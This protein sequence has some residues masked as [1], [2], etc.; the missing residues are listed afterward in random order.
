MDC[1]KPID[2]ETLLNQDIKSRILDLMNESSECDLH[3]Y[4]EADMHVMAEEAKKSYANPTS[5]E[6]VLDYIVRVST[7]DMYAAFIDDVPVGIFCMAKNT[8]NSAFIRGVHVAEEYRGQGIGEEM[9]EYAKARASNLG[10]T[11]ITLRVFDDNDGA[12]KLYKRVGFKTLYKEM[13]IEI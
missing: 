6:D 12:K 8:M 13:A 2:E 1:I 3:Y 5:I 7:E 9:M 4:D 11:S 10:Y